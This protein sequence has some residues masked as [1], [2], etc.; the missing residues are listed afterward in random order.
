MG[1]HPLQ[2]IPQSA[3]FILPS[4]TLGGIS[5]PLPFRP[6]PPYLC[7]LLYPRHRPIS[8]CRRRDVQQ[9]A[10]A[11][12][13]SQHRAPG[14][15]CR[16][17]SVA[18][19]LWLSSNVHWKLTFIFSVFINIVLITFSPGAVDIARCPWSSFFYLRHF[20]IDY[21]TFTPPGHQTYLGALRHKCA[22]LSLLNDE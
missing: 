5:L 11:P 13:P 6:L 18:A 2:G 7:S 15:V 22:P 21:F 4:L 12:S 14:T 9:W 16:T 20:N 10:T 3:V 8:S 19:D 1:K 17:R